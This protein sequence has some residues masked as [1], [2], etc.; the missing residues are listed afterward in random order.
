MNCSKGALHRERYPVFDAQ[1][2][3]K[4]AEVENLVVQDLKL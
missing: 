4:E 1:C 3:N 2:V